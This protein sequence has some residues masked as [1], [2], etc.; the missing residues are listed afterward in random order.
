MRMARFDI[1]AS[2]DNLQPVVETIPRYRP[3]LA[4]SPEICLQGSRSYR[5]ESLHRRTIDSSIKQ[6]HHVRMARAAGIVEPHESLPRGE[7][8]EPRPHGSL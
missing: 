5:D 1:D 4:F 8:P 7:E 2:E 3:V 6:G